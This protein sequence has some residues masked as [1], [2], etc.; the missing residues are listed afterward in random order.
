MFKAIMK[1]RNGSNDSGVQ[2]QPSF[3]TETL[4][5]RTLVKNQANSGARPKWPEGKPVVFHFRMPSDAQK[6]ML[7]ERIH[8]MID[9]ALKVKQEDVTRHTN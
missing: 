5:L 3:D 9:E 8:Y 2:R 4:R 7:F 1:S 6:V